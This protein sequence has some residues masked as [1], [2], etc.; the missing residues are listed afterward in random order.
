MT[1]QFLHQSQPSSA[2]RN[3]TVLDYSMRFWGS[4]VAVLPYSHT[5]N[6]RNSSL[7]SPSTPTHVKHVSLLI[8]P[9]SPQSFLDAIPATCLRLTLSEE[10]EKKNRASLH[11]LK[12]LFIFSCT[13]RPFANK[14]KLS[15]VRFGLNFIQLFWPSN[16]CMQFAIS[17][18]SDMQ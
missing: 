1:V 12:M 10:W 4:L 14:N 5:L 13:I 17:R 2:T 3:T 16:L 7:L 11:T 9:S 6:K 18:N 15:R 8:R